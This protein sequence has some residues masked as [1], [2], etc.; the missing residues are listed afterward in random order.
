MKKLVALITVV[1]VAWG[2]HSD[3]DMHYKDKE[4]DETL[5]ENPVGIQNNNGNIPDTINT[6]DIGNYKTTD[7]I[8]VGKDSLK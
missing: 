7:S 1:M 2:C 5:S 3:N 6:I 8:S 4:V